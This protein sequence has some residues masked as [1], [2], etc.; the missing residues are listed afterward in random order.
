MG[1]LN[2]DIYIMKQDVEHDN[3]INQRASAELIGLT[4]DTMSKIMLGKKRCKK[5]TALLITALIQKGWTEIED[6]NINKYFTKIKK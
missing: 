3:K 1:K 5:T 6:I 2:E 4:N